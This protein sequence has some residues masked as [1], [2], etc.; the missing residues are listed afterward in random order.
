[1]HTRPVETELD[2]N[3]NGYCIRIHHIIFGHNQLLLFYN[4]LAVQDDPLKINI[5]I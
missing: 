3:H 1:M 2:I 5:L 4:S